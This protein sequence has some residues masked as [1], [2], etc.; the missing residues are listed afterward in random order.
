M[1]LTMVSARLALAGREP[2]KNW[3]SRIVAGHK[4]S[5]GNRYLNTLDLSRHK[6]DSRASYKRYF[7]I[8]GR[9]IRE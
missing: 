1:I 4:E 7:E 5:L 2:S 8:V 6:A 9:K 3:C